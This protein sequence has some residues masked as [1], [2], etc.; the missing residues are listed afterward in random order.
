MLVSG[1]FVS[2]IEWMKGFLWSLLS[3]IFNANC[4]INVDG[5]FFGGGAGR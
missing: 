5:F 3:M 2:F 1:L 4:D